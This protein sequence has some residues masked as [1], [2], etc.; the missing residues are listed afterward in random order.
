[1]ELQQWV[2]SREIPP[3]DDDHLAYLALSHFMR[4]SFAVHQDNLDS[5]DPTE[6]P[7]KIDAYDTFAS[8]PQTKLPQNCNMLVMAV[9]HKLITLLQA[10]QPNT[11]NRL[12][13]STDLLTQRTNLY[14]CS[15]PEQ[16]VLH[17]EVSTENPDPSV[18]FQKIG[19]PLV[20]AFMEEAIH[21]DV[22]PA[23]EAG[24][25]L[26]GC[27]AVASRHGPGG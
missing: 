22:L 6:W 8:D 16:R 27:R 13:T 14:L 10:E 2:A 11:D 5:V 19:S 20:A 12:A 21:A 26:P 24:W 7:S 17:K 18:E 3:T 1:M 25:A 4:C 9:G 23:P 15:A